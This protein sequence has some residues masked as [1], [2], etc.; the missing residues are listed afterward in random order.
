VMMVGGGRQG[1]GG[2]RKGGQGEREEESTKEENGHI[3]E[4]V[5]VSFTHL[6]T[7]LNM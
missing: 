4:G 1:E 2:R 5:G 6:A 7:P 3:F